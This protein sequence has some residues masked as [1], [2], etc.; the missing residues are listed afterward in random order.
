MT[1]AV[2]GLDQ[3]TTGTTAIVLSKEGRIL[4]RAVVQHRQYF[5]Q[6]GRVE[7]DA[8]EIRDAAVRAARTALEGAGRIRPRALGIANQRETLVLWDPESGEPLGRAIVWQDRRSAKLCEE[9]KARGLEKKTR[10]RTGLPLDPYFSATKLLWRLRLEPELAARARAGELRAGTIDSWLIWSLT[11]GSSHAT[12]ITNA[13]RTLLWNLEE[14][15]WDREM[16]ELFEAPAEALPTVQ[17]S[18][19]DF[20]LAAGEDLGVELPILAAAG[21]QQAALFGQGCWRSGSAK[22]TYGTGAFFLLHTGAERAAS[23]SGLISTTALGPDGSP[24]FA[25]EGSIFSAG[26][27]IQ[28]LRDGLGI[29]EDASESEALARS[30][31][32][33][34]GVY[35]VPAFAGMGAPHWKPRARGLI[36]GLTRGTGRAHLAR[37]ALEA[38]AYGTKDLLDA[39]RRDSGIRAD[40]LKVDGGASRNDWL[41]GFLADILG[42]PVARPPDVESTALGVAALAGLGANLWT[43]PEEALQGLGRERTFAPDMA[44]SKRRRLLR[45]WR[46]A[47]DRA[48]RH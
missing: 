7:H 40:I 21:D 39:A 33:N 1:E 14:A 18:R 37:A 46:E 13:S 25:L 43:K 15:R 29:L 11:R 9:L 24:A 16:L 4:S 28:W 12:D 20:G 31:D 10:A 19:S 47:V 48:L 38:M 32:G 27:T 26:A 3:G 2:L 36:S 45:G 30:L 44:E 34:D 42:E 41:L 6:P 17:P 35:L 5:P 22:C 23:R 8:R